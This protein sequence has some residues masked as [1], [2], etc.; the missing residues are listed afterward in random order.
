[1][2]SIIGVVIIQIPF[3]G[4]YRSDFTGLSWS[5]FLKKP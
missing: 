2:F 1:M 5:G 3:E 4:D